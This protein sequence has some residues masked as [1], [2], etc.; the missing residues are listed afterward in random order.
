MKRKDIRSE[1]EKDEED[2]EV[3]VLELLLKGRFQFAFFGQQSQVPHLSG[4]HDLGKERLSHTNNHNNN[5]STN[6]IKKEEEEEEECAPERHW[7]GPSN[8]CSWCETHLSA[9]K[10]L[11]PFDPSGSISKCRLVRA[12]GNNRRKEGREE[13][14]G[15]FTQSLRCD[16]APAPRVATDSHICCS[17]ISHGNQIRDRRVTGDSTDE[18]K[19]S[20]QSPSATSTTERM[21][22][23]EKELTL[24]LVLRANKTLSSGLI[25]Q[26]HNMNSSIEIQ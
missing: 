1:E 24:I 25:H 3:T 13:R 12:R 26:V 18:L 8:Q 2:E 7:F 23:K 19:F 22:R 20:T 9:P 17:C 15:E 6:E 11:R 16:S 14:R 21:E 4:E 10:F 5:H